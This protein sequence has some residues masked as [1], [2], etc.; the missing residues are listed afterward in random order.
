MGELHNQEIVIDY[1]VENFKDKPCQ[2][3]IIEQINRLCRQYG[4]NPHGDAE[5]EIKSKTSKA[6][7]F[8]Y[9]KGKTNP[10]LSVQLPARPKDKTAKVKKQVFTFHVIIKNVW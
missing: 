4:G 8:T 1:E 3:D 10:V 7:E 6:I 9:P 5:W 2:L